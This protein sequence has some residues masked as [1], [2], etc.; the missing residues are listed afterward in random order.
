MFGS[1]V[2]QPRGVL[3]NEHKYLDIEFVLQEAP[4]LPKKNITLLDNETPLSGAEVANLSPAFAET[5]NKSPFSKGVIITKIRAGSFSHRFGFRNG[6]IIL[7][8]GDKKIKLV[9][10]LLTELSRQRNI[11]WSIKILR[12]QKQL[13]LLIK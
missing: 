6:D 8:I 12:N 11:G 9:R 2:G 10:N 1:D 13:T 5:L 4:E 7:M 3:W